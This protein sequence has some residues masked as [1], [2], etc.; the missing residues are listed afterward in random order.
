MLVVLSWQIII[1]ADPSVWG[2]EGII[3]R[4]EVIGM[5]VCGAL[6]ITREHC[7]F[8]AWSF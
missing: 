2:F 6:D 3:Q 7:S 8:I 4:F 5:N 1:L